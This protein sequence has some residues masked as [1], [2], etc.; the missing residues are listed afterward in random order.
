MRIQ[1]HFLIRVVLLNLIA[2][3]LAAQWQIGQAGQPYVLDFDN[4]VSGVNAAAYAGV[5]Y[6]QNP[7]SGAL[8]SDAWALYGMSSGD[9]RFGDSATG[10]DYGRGFSTG[11]VSTGGTYAFDVDTGAAVN[12]ALGVQPG[13]SDFTPGYHLL[14]ISNQT[15]DTVSAVDFTYELHIY[16]DQ[17]RSSLLEFHWGTDTLN[18]THEALYDHTSIASAAAMPVWEKFLFS[19][20]LTTLIL[21]GEFLYLKW[22]TDDVGGSGSRDEIALDNITISFRS[23]LNLPPTITNIYHA[24]DTP[25]SNQPVNIFARIT[26]AQG[27][28][29]AYVRWGHD[30]VNLINGIGMQVMAADSFSTANPVAALPDSSIVYYRVIAVDGS[31]SALADTSPVF[32]YLVLDPPAMASS[33]DLMITEIM[34]NPS[35][36]SDA[37]GEYFEL[38]NSGAATYDLKGYILEDAGSDST[39]IGASVRI[40]PREFIVMARDSNQTMNGGFR[41]DYQY[42]GM[43]LSNLNDEIILLNPA[44]DTLDKV[45]YTAAF[46]GAA[47]AALVYAGATHQDNNDMS[48]WLPAVR[49]EARFTGAIGDFGS[50]GSEGRE[51]IVDHLVYVGGSWS[52][53]PDSSSGQRQGVVRRG[54][55][56]L[57][58]GD[59]RIGSMRVE[60]LAGLDLGSGKLTVGDTLF[61]LADSTGYSQLIGE[62]DGQVTWSSHLQSINARWFNLAIPLNTSLA[63]VQLSNSGFINTFADVSGDTGAVN[64]WY[65]DAGTLNSSTGEGTWRPVSNNSFAPLDQGLSMYLGPPHFG[66]LPQQL[67]ATGSLVNGSR[68]IPLQNLAGSTQY[69]FIANPFTSAIGWD[70]ITRD[71]PGINKTYFIYDEGPDS[72]WVAYNALSGAVSGAASGHIAPGQAFFVN[73]NGQSTLDLQQDSRSI[74]QNPALFKGVRPPGINIVA[75]TSAD[76]SDHTYLGFMPWAKDGL[77]PG[78]DVIK[79]MNYARETPSI[80]SDFAHRSFMYNFLPSAFKAKSVPISLE[81]ALADSLTMDFELI[82]IDPSWNL[83]LEDHLSGREHDLREGAIEVVHTPLN[84]KRQFTL[85]ISSSGLQ[86]EKDDR[87]GLCVSLGGQIICEEDQRVAK[88]ALFDAVGRKVWEQQVVGFSSLAVPIAGLK[89]GIY[90]LVMRDAGNKVLKQEKC[91]IGQA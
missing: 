14:K 39:I 77:D 60:P 51:Q 8:D 58:G 89:D 5:G 28:D 49:R 62:V 33:G 55:S 90:V 79:R 65:Y 26:D 59:A 71:N 31:D 9:V 40:R 29:T 34:M 3:S 72:A 43:T 45:R 4:G 22:F 7:G 69:N 76:R 21:P 20:Q 68:Q 67:T 10:G 88:I 32:S 78:I 23:N 47:G 44:G 50:P 36:V 56:V 12:I 24:P 16:N 41:A 80:Y 74:N 70:E 91:L 19:G 18:L 54:E 53:V 86:L 6:A 83:I 66:Q 17:N 35:A 38:Y 64:I 57:L 27:I 81:L 48:L 2:V 75:T 84:G 87:G 42:S 30:S 15:G 82:D 52:Q 25:S 13:G 85:H 1:P 11:G 73:A 37:R 46:W 63:T 61:L